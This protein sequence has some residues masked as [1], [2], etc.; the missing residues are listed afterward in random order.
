MLWTPHIVSVLLSFFAQCSHPSPLFRWHTMRIQICV[1]QIYLFIY[2][3]KHD[4][5]TIVP[6]NVMWKQKPEER[7][8]NK[9]KTSDLR[10]CRF[11]GKIN[12]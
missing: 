3:Y 10:N 12:G 9:I 1:I 2:I 8:K 11:K 5:R 7:L 6:E 4:A